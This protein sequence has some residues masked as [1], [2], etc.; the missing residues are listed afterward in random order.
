MITEVWLTQPGMWTR[1]CV[2]EENT[3]I[4]MLCVWCPGHLCEVMT[5]WASV[6]SGHGLGEG[7]QL[8]EVSGAGQLQRYTWGGCHATVY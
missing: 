8:G 3:C 4:H 7:R 2:S 6:R 1:E 5:K